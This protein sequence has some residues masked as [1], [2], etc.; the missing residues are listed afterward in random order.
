[1]RPDGEIRF[2]LRLYAGL[3]GCDYARVR[4]IGPR[5]ALDVLDDAFKYSRGTAHQDLGLHAIDQIC[6]LVRVGGWVV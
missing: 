3:V 4:N 6:S 5:R 2:C 1:M